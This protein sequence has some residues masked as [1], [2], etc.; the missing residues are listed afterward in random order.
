[1]KTNPMR[2]NPIKLMQDKTQ[3]NNTMY[4]KEQADRIRRY[5]TAKLVE[6]RRSIEDAKQNKEERSKDVTGW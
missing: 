2:T 4:T 5:M 1:M 6:A 3:R